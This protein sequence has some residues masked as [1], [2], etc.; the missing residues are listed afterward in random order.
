[1]LP[2]GTLSVI[3]TKMVLPTYFSVC[4]QTSLACRQT[5]KHIGKIFFV[6]V[7]L[8]NHIYTHID[9]Q[10]TEISVS[11]LGND[12]FVGEETDSRKNAIS[13]QRNGC[14]RINNSVDVG[15]SLKELQFAIVAIPYRAMPA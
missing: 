2:L 9:L 10:F 5:E 6:L 11:Y 12:E 13:K 4:L 3:N 7:Y 1:M 15:E 14:Q 8:N